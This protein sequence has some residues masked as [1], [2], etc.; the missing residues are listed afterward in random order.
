MADRVL[1]KTISLP[2]DNKYYKLKFTGSV[3]LPLDSTFSINASSSK[4]T[5][6]IALL[7]TIW[8][9]TLPGPSYTL[10]TLGLN[11]NTFNGEILYKNFAA[12]FTSSPVKSLTTKV[13]YKYLN[14]DNN[15]D[16]ITYTSGTTSVTN[17]LFE[18]KK[19][20]VGVEIGYKFTKDLKAT[21]GYD[22]LKIKRQRDDIPET[23]DS[24]YF[25][26]VKYTPLDFIGGRIK[27]QRLERDSKFES[28]EVPP[29][30]QP[31]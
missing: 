2:P 16:E 8:T 13:Y 18:Y 26:Q 11:D 6:D 29:L 12:V 23:E 21:A 1:M 10:T 9:S 7:D 14:K 19:N 20:N 22:Y 30:I 17:H 28:P 5:S 27:Y 24:T 4:L 25:V 3:K 15:S 31:I